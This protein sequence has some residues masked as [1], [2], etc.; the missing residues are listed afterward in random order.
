MLS[1]RA[2]ITGYCELPFGV[3]GT[4]PEFPVAVRRQILCVGSF[5]PLLCGWG[6]NSGYQI[7]EVMLLAS[8]SSHKLLN[9]F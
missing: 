2:G 5:L 3:L 8:E 4:E 9:F 7:F 1:P 6:S